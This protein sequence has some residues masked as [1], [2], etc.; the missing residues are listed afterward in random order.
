[1]TERRQA[2]VDLRE[3]LQS[4]NDTVASLSETLGDTE[5]HRLKRDWPAKIIENWLIPALVFAASWF[6][7]FRVMQVQFEQ[8]Q[9]NQAE[10]VKIIDNLKDEVV[11]LRIKDANHESRMDE[12][13][14]RLYHIESQHDQ[15]EKAKR[16]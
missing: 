10:M 16:R 15:D 1:M 12:A 2:D 11:N 9:H 8:L 6:I 14:N 13:W 4:L 3:M 5:W 7:A